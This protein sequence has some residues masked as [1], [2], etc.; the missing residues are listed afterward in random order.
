MSTAI[1]KTQP[2]SGCERIMRQTLHAVEVAQA[3][4]AAIAEGIAT[5]STSHLRVMRDYEEEL[6]SLDRE[7][8][9]SVTSTIS[10]VS[11]PEARELLACLKFILE[12][13][14]IGD[15]LLN[16]VNR[17]GAVLKRMDQ[18][19]VKDL[20]LMASIIERMLTDV[21]RAFESRELNPCLAV[22]RAD[23]E[24]DRMRNMIFMRHVENPENQ[25]RQESFHIVFMTQTLERAGDH[26]KN[27]AEE[28]CHLVTK[29]SI[30]H[31]L[32]ASDKPFEEMFLDWM[33]KQEAGKR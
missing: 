31:L 18:Q 16:F 11:E 10:K 2:E 30:R 4:A 22:L 26:V 32:R 8:N 24:I 13:E 33:R 28:V 29:Q 21:H 17:A 19:D 23:S 27:L 15:L 3:A 5:A 20:T 1:F 12:L 7:I 14:R 6:D 25:P 9:Q